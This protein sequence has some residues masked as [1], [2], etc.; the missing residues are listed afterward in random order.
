MSRWDGWV[1]PD[2]PKSASPPDPTQA[3]IDAPEPT[4]RVHA[5][6]IFPMGGTPF[7]P[8]SECPHWCKRCSGSG[9][10]GIDGET[11]EAIECPD[12]LDE[13]TGKGTGESWPDA[14]FVCVICH[15]SGMDGHPSIPLHVEPLPPGDPASASAA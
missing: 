5:E 12:C 9:V 6:P 15:R 13:S 11:G 10:I 4:D 1:K 2:L 7:T 3:L 8:T 14:P